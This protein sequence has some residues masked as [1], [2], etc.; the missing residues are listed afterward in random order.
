MGHGVVIKSMFTSQVIYHVTPPIPPSSVLR[1]I[2]KIEQAFLWLGTDKTTGAKC[3]VNWETVCR[4]YGLGG[5]VCL[6]SSSLPRP[7]DCGGHGSNTKS[8]LK[9]RWVRKTMRRDGP[10][11]VLCFDHHHHLQIG[12]VLLFGLPFG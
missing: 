5:S 4:P 9:C 2:N 7:L 8:R 3:K 11:H 6:I 12:S 10:R 1:S